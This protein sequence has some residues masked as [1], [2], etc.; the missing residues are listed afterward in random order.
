ME[1]I[2]VAQASLGDRLAKL[3]LRSMS[4]KSPRLTQISD[5][6]QRIHS[7]DLELANQ[8]HE[9]QQRL[10]STFSGRARPSRLH[11]HRDPHRQGRHQRS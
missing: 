6:L 10:A 9:L 2:S 4:K 3:Y 11:R 7:T 5:L 8:V 1:L